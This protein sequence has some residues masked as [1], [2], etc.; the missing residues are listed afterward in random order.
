M[1]YG[2]DDVIVLKKFVLPDPK[3]EMEKPWKKI[4]KRIEKYGEV[5]EEDIQKE[6]RK[7]RARRRKPKA[8][9]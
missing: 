9:S 7:V 1:V 8:R 2:L 4:D 6:I 3:K 5:S